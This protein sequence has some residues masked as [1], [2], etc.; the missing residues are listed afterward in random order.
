[1]QS[2]RCPHCDQR[3]PQ[4]N[5]PLRCQ[6]ALG[7]R[8]FVAVGP[9]AHPL[10]RALIDAL[11]YDSIYDAANPLGKL[12]SRTLES[13]RASVD[14]ARTILVPIPL[15]HKRLRE[16]G[17]NQSDLIAQYVAEKLTAPLRKDILIRSRQTEQQ[18]KLSLKQREENVIGAFSANPSPLLRSYTII[19]ID[20]VVTTGA[21]MREAAQALR[22]AGA[23]D[24][25]GAA[26]AQG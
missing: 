18:A 17:F 1:M 2:Q 12:L 14:N 19:L 9:Y 8:R 23:K 5:L 16:R 13:L 22:R 11:K 15:H 7:I 21:T 26:V 10:L 24:I 25:W 4:G 3:L 6:K 20:D